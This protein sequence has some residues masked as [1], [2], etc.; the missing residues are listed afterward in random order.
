[1]SKKINKKN[2]KIKIYITKILL[3]II[4]TLVSLIFIKKDNLFKE[5]FKYYIY[6]NNFNFAYVKKIYTK[7]FGD[8]LPFNTLFKESISPVFHEQITYISKEPYLDGVKLSLEDNYLI[9][10]IESGIVVYIGEKENL[11]NTVIIETS[12]G[13]DIWYSNINANI[14]LYDYINKDDIIGE[15]CD[16]YIYITLKKD[17][18][19]INY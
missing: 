11:G 3:T 4:I 18:K 8:I 7:Y 13:V 9:P 14:K 15:E 5:K 19:V 2:T 12:D 10:A 1:M 17:G 16:N 6:E